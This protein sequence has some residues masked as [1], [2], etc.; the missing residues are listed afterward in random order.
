MSVSGATWNIGDGKDD[1]KE[2]G[3]TRL[4]QH[5]ADIIGLQ[6]AGDREKMIKHWCHDHGWH[7]WLGEGPGAS[8][9]PIIWNPEVVKRL[10]TD[11]WPATP[12]TNTGRLGVGPSM[13]KAKVWNKVRFEI[14]DDQDPTDLLFVNGHGPASV[15]APKRRRLAEDWVG[16]LADRLEHRERS[17]DDDQADVL[18]VMDGNAKPGDRLW[19][20]LRQLGMHQ[21][22]HDPTK[23]GRTIDLTWTLGCTGS[24]EVIPMPGDHR[25]AIF[26]KKEK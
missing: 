16:E 10:N 6:E 15:W 8:S 24:T 1:L 9:V 11:T 7:L 18:V 21:H 5:G 22:T 17:I 12:P 3:L 4:L 13:V 23:G 2:R 26:T 19:V 25:A 20:P 14:L